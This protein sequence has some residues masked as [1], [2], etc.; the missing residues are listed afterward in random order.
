MPQLDAH[1]RLFLAIG[2]IVTMIGLLAAF[3]NG[4]AEA[5]VSVAFSIAGP[6]LAGAGLIARAI[7]AA[8]ERTL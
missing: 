3:G 2:T 8:R 1:A 5:Q 7:L 4:R 6:V